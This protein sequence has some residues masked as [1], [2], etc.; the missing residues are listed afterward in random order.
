MPGIEIWEDNRSVCSEDD[1]LLQLF[2]KPLTRQIRVLYIVGAHKFQERDLFNRMFPFLEHILLFEP[3]PELKMIL[4]QIAH[5]DSRIQVF[6]LAMSDTNGSADFYITNNEAASSSLLPL[7]KHRNIFPQV[8]VTETIRVQTRK[9]ESVINEHQLVWPEMLFL[10]VQGAEYRILSSLSPALLSSI[11]V[12]Y[13]EAS[14]EDVYVGAKT[15]DDL[16]MLLSSDFVCL[17]FA[18]LTSHTPTHGNAL[19]VNKKNIR[20]L[21]VGRIERMKRKLSKYLKP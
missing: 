18:P 13:T 14:K 8:H 19:F 3:Q 15:L 9:L 6:P 2:G 11:L 4:E 17:G 5:T 12:I 16:K 20:Q 21:S 7:G 10:D 1:L